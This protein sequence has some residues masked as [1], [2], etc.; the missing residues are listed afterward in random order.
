MPLNPMPSNPSPL[1]KA[2]WDALKPHEE[3]LDYLKKEAMRGNFTCRCGAVV[4]GFQY[5]CIHGEF[6][7]HPCYDA[8]IPKPRSK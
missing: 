1:H 4:N 5:G 6:V 3:L 7:C 2:I 8:S